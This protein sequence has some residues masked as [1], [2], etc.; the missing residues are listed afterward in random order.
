MK[1]SNYYENLKICLEILLKI[2]PNQ[3]YQNLNLLRKPQHFAGNP[4][5]NQGKRKV[6]NS[7]FAKTS[8]FAWKFF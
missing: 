7:I 2:K 5:K 8:K 4:F 1:M 3:K 6:L